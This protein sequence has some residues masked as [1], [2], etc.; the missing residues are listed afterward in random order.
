MYCSRMHV[1]HVFAQQCL[2]LGEVIMCI[3]NGLMQISKSSIKY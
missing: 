2:V 3:V 1:G